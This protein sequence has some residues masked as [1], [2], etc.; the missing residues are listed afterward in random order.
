MKITLLF[1]LLCL[2][3][4]QL[5]AQDAMLPDS[6]KAFLDKSIDL[7][8]AN[9]INR[10]TVDWPAL[11]KR[12]YEKTAAAK[13][14]EDLLPVYPYLFEQIGDYHGAL[15]Y[16]GKSYYWKH[17]SAYDNEVVKAAVK[18]QDSVL[19]KRL[20]GNIGYI[21]LPGNN[22]FAAK[23]INEDA[24]K[25][26]MAIAAVDD[27][28]IKGWIIDL[29]VNTGGNMYQ[30]LA[31]LGN[32]L[33]D[34]KL[35]AFVNQHQ[36][37]DGVWRIKNGNIYIDSSQV[38]NLIES[39]GAGLKL[40]PMAVLISGQTASSGEVVAISTVGRKKTVLI[41]ENSAGYTTAN[42]GFVINQ[43]AG[44]NLAIGFDADRSGYIYR[45]YVAPNI[46]INGGDNFENL[47]VDKKVIAAKKW[48]LKTK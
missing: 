31:G 1:C 27:I 4:Y 41:G 5:K 15:K 46:V 17:A 25:I 32:L 10:D 38:S 42:Q 13:S 37:E 24:Q 39:R 12:I 29:R 19:V 21:L 23:R 47:E 45:S 8:Q 43:D 14:I 44:L 7:V 18:K 26:R 28:K 20:S 30:M 40:L 33:G 16:K 22:D 36:Q 48:I 9:A 34:G 6:V 2:A 3:G 11:R 35:G